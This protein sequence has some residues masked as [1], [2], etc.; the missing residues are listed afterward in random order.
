[1]AD[2]VAVFRDTEELDCRVPYRGL[3]ASDI[4]PKE[5]LDYFKQPCQNIGRREVILQVRFTECVTRFFESL[6]NKRPIP[7]LR[8]CYAQLFLGKFAHVR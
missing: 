6:P 3:I 5:R 4:N 2:G 1:M 7:G 8:I